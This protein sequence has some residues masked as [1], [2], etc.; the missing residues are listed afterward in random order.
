M[1]ITASD[2]KQAPIVVRL[3]KPEDD[4]AYG[5]AIYRIVNTAYRSNAGWTHESHLIAKDRI[6][7][8]NVKLVLADKVNPVLLA[9]DSETNQ[10]LGTVQLDPAEHYGDFGH[11]SKPDYFFDYSTA[12]TFP[13]DQQILLGLISVDPSQQSRGIGRQLVE[14]GLRHARE[15]LGRKQAVVYVLFQRK[16]LVGWYKRVGFVDYGEKRPYPDILNTRQDDV[17][18][19][20]LRLAL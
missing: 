16:E 7:R 14:A 9:F 4:A 19:T 15:V 13:K 18:F 2:K 8:E 11:Y 10:V 6:S 1:T 17:H 3:A 5:D 12:D 20:V